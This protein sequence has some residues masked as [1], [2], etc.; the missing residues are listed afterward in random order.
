MSSTAYKNARNS[1][2][3]ARAL[4]N[5]LRGFL[6]YRDWSKDLEDRIDA[7]EMTQ[8]Q[9]DE[10][11]KL[12]TK[13]RDLLYKRKTDV[14]NQHV[15]PAM[16]NLTVLVEVMHEES[17]IRGKFE[18]DLKA[19]FLSKSSKRGKSS[20]CIFERF[21]AACCTLTSAI[22]VDRRTREKKKTLSPD[23]RLILLD[24]MQTNNIS[25][26]VCHSKS[27]I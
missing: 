23:F 7:G 4:V 13:K 15:F 8:E 9:I 16:A 26:D 10:G 19:L 11:N 20:K 24:I 3:H 17:Y 18:D 27:Q 21:I 12:L 2:H 25:E 22:E 14:L 1:Y 5:L 6:Q